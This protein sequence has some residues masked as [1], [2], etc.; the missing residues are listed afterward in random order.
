M[1]EISTYSL[2]LGAWRA[3]LLATMVVALTRMLGVMTAEDAR[4]P[5]E[6]QKEAVVAWMG[7]ILVAFF[8]INLTAVFTESDLLANIIYK[9][10]AMVQHGGECE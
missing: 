1:Y 10:A 5:L 8:T 7:C 9:E 4:D 3:G 6:F 2:I